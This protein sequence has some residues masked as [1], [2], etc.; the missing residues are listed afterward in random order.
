[1]SSTTSGS[2]PAGTAATD[3]RSHDERAI[4]GTTRAHHPARVDH[5]PVAEWLPER[6][7]HLLDRIADLEAGG[8]HADADRIRR[9]AIRAYSRR[10]N[11]ATAGRL[12][13]LADEASKIAASPVRAPRDGH[14]ARLFRRRRP[15]AHPAPG[16][17]SEGARSS[18]Q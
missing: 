3:R 17:T 9:S 7:R 2:A 13:S 5:A 11:E 10:W 4:P 1:M 18:P 16:L 8:R 15:A 12:D 14:L 6:Y